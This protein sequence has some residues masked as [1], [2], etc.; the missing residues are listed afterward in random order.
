MAKRLGK[1]RPED[2]P[3]AHPRLADKLAREFPD[4]RGQFDEARRL[5]IDELRQFQK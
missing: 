4:L 3:D 5:N 2:I 1:M